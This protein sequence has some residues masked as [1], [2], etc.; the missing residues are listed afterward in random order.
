MF[1][2]ALVLGAVG[3]GLLAPDGLHAIGY[4]CILFAHIIALTTRRIT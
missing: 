4:S 2:M 3:C 1:T